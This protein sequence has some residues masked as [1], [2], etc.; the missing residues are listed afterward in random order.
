MKIAEA[1]IEVDTRQAKFAKDLKT[2]ESSVKTSTDR[3]QQKFKAL[4]P[5]FRKV[6]M[7]MTVA[8]GAITAALGLAVKSS[9]DFNKEMAN[10]ATL[11]PGA[12]KR[13][14]ELKGAI[15]TMA[16]TV[17]KDTADLAQGAYQVISAFGDTADTVAILKI[18]AKA[19]TAGVADTTSAINLLSAVT[20]GYGDTSKE[21]VQKAS[22]LAFMTV[23]LGQTNFPQLEAS[24]GRVIPLTAELGVSEEELFAVMATGTGVTGKAAEVS[25]QLRGIMQ[26]LMSPTADMTKLFEKKGYVSGKAM[27][28]DLG[29]AGSLELVKN[30][31]DASNMPLQKY[32]SSI[33][34]Q[35][36]ALALTGTQADTYTQKLKAMMDVTDQTDIAFKEQTEGV[37]KAGFAFNQAK[38]RISVLASEIGDRLLPMVT[39]LI[40]RITEIVKRMSDW[41][42]EH[43]VLAGV[44]VKTTA[45]IGGLLLVLGPLLIMLPSL[46]PLI[47]AIGVAFHVATGPIGWVTAAIIAATAAFIYFYKT[48]EQFRGAI[49]K[50]GAYLE[51]FGRVVAEVFKAVGANIGTFLGWLSVEFPNVFRDIVSAVGTI[52]KNLGANIAN[53]VKYLGAKLNPKNWLKKIEPPDWTPL[54]EGFEATV[55]EIPNLIG[56]NLDKAKGILKEKLTAVDAELVK[57]TDAANEMGNTIVGASITAGGAL[58]DLKGKTKEL[59]E[60]EKKRLEEIAE[61]ERALTQEI[62]ELTHTRMEIDQKAFDER[63]ERLRELGVSEE[64]IQKLIAARRAKIQ[65]EITKKEL[66][67][68]EKRKKEAE[69][70]AEKKKK[71]AEDAAKERIRLEKEVTGKVFSFTHTR[72]EIEQKAFDDYIKRLKES[73]VSD[74]L[75]KKLIA[76]RH[77]KL[78]EEK[79]KKEKEEAEEREKI[80]KDEAE[81]KAEEHKKALEKREAAE[82]AFRE[83]MARLMKDETALLKIEIDKRIKKYRE[84]GWTEKEIQEWVAA[85]RKQKEEEGTRKLRDELEKRF[86]N[87]NEFFNGVKGLRLRNLD[88]FVAWWKNLSDEEKKNLK[89]SYDRWNMWKTDIEKIW[90]G[91]VSS[92]KSAFV[93]AVV[94]IIAGMQSVASA[95]NSLADAVYSTVIKAFIEWAIEAAKAGNKVALAVAGVVTVVK[96]LG[97][98]IRETT[99]HFETAWGRIGRNFAHTTMEMGEN[100]RGFTDMLETEFNRAGL[101]ISKTIEDAQYKLEGLYQSQIDL[102]KSTREQLIAELDNYYDYRM[103]RELSLDELL[104]LSAE[105]RGKIE[106]GEISKTEESEAEKAA[107]DKDRAVSR[108][109][110]IEEGY[111]RESE[112]L[113][114]KIA[115]T[116]IEIKFLEL[117]IEREEHG[118]SARAR[119]LEAE[120]DQMLENYKESVEAYEDAERRKQAATDETRETVEEANEEMRDSTE[121]AAEAMEDAMRGTAEAIEDAAED[122]AG[123]IEEAT[124]GM[125]SAI[126]T[127]TDEIVQAI[128]DMAQDIINAINDMVDKINAKLKEIPED[129]EFDIWGILHMPSIPLIGTQYFDIFGSYHAPSIPTAQIGIPYIP[130]T[131]PVIVHKKEAILNPRQAREWRAGGK[132]GGG[133]NVTFQRGAVV[134]R[135]QNLNTKADVEELVGLV[136]DT[137][138]KTIEKKIRGI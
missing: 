133:G 52:L 84:E 60:E 61:A 96:V 136:E 92:I 63:M 67:E 87:W 32:I 49:Q 114:R 123:A 47:T 99:R 75:I 102:Q 53:W 40:E 68:A 98:R 59:S 20:K 89:E 86:E 57:V 132:A 77:A 13:V 15:R 3:M 48:N 128:R 2:M 8:G 95:L 64:L 45:V 35:T 36:L 54:L 22:D 39:P 27:L 50:T 85:F 107:R 125:V 94:S 109:E 44:I 55:T 101:A 73:N 66:E 121:V 100:I 120:L 88:E 71:L 31:A 131:M 5:T 134:M 17:G 51:F 103:L 130:R 104:N 4:A 62:F 21:A 30:M 83:E 37:N 80:A 78:E 113:R 108:L 43:P 115:L 105:T 12:T 33:E 38:I 126:N 41:A 110:M 119:Q 137:M 112:L 58:E 26:S 82:L 138:T 124:R 72:K 90:D 106:R 1:Y 46:P 28:A 10:I 117:K 29:L 42:K 56:I 91:F 6:G 93:D 111:R 34:G 129:I 116:E 7:G 127:M 69:K 25:T 76:A 118:H 135:V 19:A 24:I 70:E 79:T 74:E 23:K 16:V 9:I 14:I 11:I 81:K 18:A 65:E 122:M 97:I